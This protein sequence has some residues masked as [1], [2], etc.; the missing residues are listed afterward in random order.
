MVDSDIDPVR[1][2][3]ARLE[4]LRHTLGRGAYV[5]DP[6]GALVEMTAGAEELL[7]WSSEELRGQNMH[8]AIHYLRADGSRYPGS[9]C[10]LMGVLESGVDFGETDDTFVTK[11]GG[12]LS[13][14]YVSSPV[15]VGDE[16]VGAVLAFWPR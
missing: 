13:V 7:G 2:Q 11:D 15:I 1:A 10:P 16:I 6:G 14:A 12:M 4:A 3:V 9:E 5:L 8:E